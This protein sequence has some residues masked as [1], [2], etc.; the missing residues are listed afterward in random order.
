[1]QVSLAGNENPVESCPHESAEGGYQYIYGGP[2]EANEELSSEFA[3]IVADD[4]IEEL[5]GELDDITPYWSGSSTAFDPDLDDYLFR[6][7]AESLGHKDAFN[8]SALNIERLLETKVEA[9]DRQC[10]LRLLRQCH[11]CSG[12][13][14]LR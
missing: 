11:N 9:A 12:D 4:V 5:S 8:E 14:P 13:I 7:S 3:G 6:S 1:M 2:S 10:L